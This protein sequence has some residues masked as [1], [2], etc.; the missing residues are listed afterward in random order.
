[1]PPRLRSTARRSRVITCLVLLAPAGFV[2]DC[3][4]P[5]PAEP[6]REARAVSSAPPPAPSASASTAAPDEAPPSDGAIEGAKLPPRLGAAGA[7][8]R[9]IACG[10]TRCQAGQEACVVKSSPAAARAWACVDAKDE[11]TSEGAYFCDDASDCESGR[12]CCASFASAASYYACTKRSGPDS[13]CADEICV[14]GDG[15]ACP[16]GQAC[17]GGRC[18]PKTAARASCGAT[19]CPAEKP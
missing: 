8:K 14:E 6:A 5:R 2:L 18:Q 3:G 12:V 4:G 10:D 15:A 7:T 19:R 13:D 11:A 16:P 1:M 17:R 9:T